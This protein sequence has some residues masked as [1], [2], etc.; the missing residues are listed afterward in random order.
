MEVA[1]IAAL[2]ILGHEFNK[3]PK[4]NQSHPHLLAHKSQYPFGGTNRVNEVNQHESKLVSESLARS[5]GDD[6]RHMPYHNNMVPFISKG[7]A[8]NANDNVKT[9]RLEIFTGATD[10]D[11]SATGTY[12]NKKEVTPMFEPELG[13]S[14]VNGMPSASE[15]E[16]FSRYETGMYRSGVNSDP[17]SR[18]QVGPGL[19]ISP[20][21]VAGGHF[22]PERDFRMLPNNVNEYRI[23][24]LDS[25]VK[26][27][28]S[29]VEKATSLPNKI[30]KKLPDRFFYSGQHPTMATG[31]VQNAA[32]ANRSSV[33]D[34]MGFQ[35]RGHE[36]NRG[37]GGLGAATPSHTLRQDSTRDVNPRSEGVCS[38]WSVPKPPSY[39]VGT[40]PMDRT[41]D[42]PAQSRESCGRMGGLSAPVEQ[43]AMGAQD[44]PDPTLRELSNSYPVGMGAPV[45]HEGLSVGGLGENV[46]GAPQRAT[47]LSSYEGNPTMTGPRA[48]RHFLSDGTQRSQMSTFPSGNASFTMGVQPKGLGNYE[49]R[50]E[51]VV[52]GKFHGPQGINHLQDAN[53]V[54]SNFSGTPDG[55]VYNNPRQSKVYDRR[56]TQ[57]QLGVVKESARAIVGYREPMGSN[58]VGPTRTRCPPTQNVSNN[59]SPL[60]NHPTAP[61][62]YCPR[63]PLHG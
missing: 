62:D 38:A 36:G 39:A 5:K 58:P 17:N 14:H 31:G 13:R 60:P 61:A 49:L 54:M 7:G 40:A 46:S 57:P 20:D 19:G 15:G 4:S 23:N 30:S 52:P 25:Y 21:Q 11:A 47:T 35:T 10:A 18:M 50:E 28:A 43:R 63:L 48:K 44:R 1:L 55:N 2:A 9:T 32:T 24:Q 26:V 8:Q 51:N 41:F 12:R 29:A 33:Y 45:S 59:C 3:Q 16:R 34:G 56:Y 6:V 37:G 42:M 22:H 53:S 27:G